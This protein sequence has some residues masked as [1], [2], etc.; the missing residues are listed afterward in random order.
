MAPWWGKFGSFWDHPD[1]PCERAR[2]KVLPRN[3]NC[4]LTAALSTT[5]RRVRKRYTEGWSLTATS[6]WI[7]SN[8]SENNS[9]L[10]SV[11][12]FKKYMLSWKDC[13]GLTVSVVSQLWQLKSTV[14]IYCLIEN[15]CTRTVDLNET[16]NSAIY[17]VSLLMQAV[18][19]DLLA[20]VL[21]RGRERTSPTVTA[22]IC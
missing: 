20:V 5:T 18:A 14:V 19:D 10:R 15:I 6:R 8:L 13:R 21:S 12:T 11:F 1:F 17:V 16:L 9:K 3:R 2:T 7:G 4:D 22:T